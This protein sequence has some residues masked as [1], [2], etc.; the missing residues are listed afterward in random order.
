[1]DHCVIL[2]NIISG[3]VYSVSD[4]VNSNTTGDTIQTES[5]VSTGKE[6]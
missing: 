4:C 2:F 1:M 3:S 5:T 6:K